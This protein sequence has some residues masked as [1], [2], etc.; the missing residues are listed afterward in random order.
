MHRFRSSTSIFS[1]IWIRFLHTVLK[2]ARNRTVH[3][4]GAVLNVRCSLF[5]LILS[6]LLSAV[7]GGR[8][9]YFTSGV[10]T[11]DTVAYR[12]GI[13]LLRTYVKNMAT[14]RFVT[15]KWCKT[16]YRVYR[17]LSS[18]MSLACPICL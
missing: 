4:Q 15:V 5:Y 17:Y 3:F 7:C 10:Y 1:L 18:C 9:L 12:S 8:R 2:S 13:Q 16:C 11:A 14:F 6:G